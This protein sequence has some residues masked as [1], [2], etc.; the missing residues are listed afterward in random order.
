[1]A[2]PSLRRASAQFLLTDRL[3]LAGHA[4]LA[5]AATAVPSRFILLCSLAL[6]ALAPPPAAAEDPRLVVVHATRAV[7]GDSAEP[8]RRRWTAQ[9]DRNPADRGAA[10]GLATLARLTYDYA[11]AERL[12]RRLLADS[13]RPDRHSALARLGLARGLEGRGFS[14]EA[15]PHFVRAR[16]EARVSGDAPTEGE[17]LL[18]L[19]FIRARTEGLTV[20]EALLDTAALLI[21]DSALALRAQLRYRRAI[22][23]S[24][25]G[26]ADAPVEAE[27][28]IALARR[29]RDVRAEADGFR[30]LGQVLVYAQ[31]FDSALVV[32]RRAED[33]FRRARDRSALAA[34]LVWQ[35]QALG[36]LGRF[37]EMAELMRRARAEGEASRNPAT[38]AVAHRSLGALALMMGDYAAAARGL[39]TAL[40]ISTETGDSL[41][42]QTTRKFL[43]DVALAAGDLATAR[44]LTLEQLN[45]ARRTEQPA[46]A[47]EAHVLLA[48]LAMR[49]R[50]WDGAERHL[51]E[52]GDVLRQLPGAHDRL[53]LLHHEGRLAHAR[54]DLDQAERAFSAFVRGFTGQS[55]PELA[56]F[57]ARVR[58]ADIHAARG[59]LARAER[60]MRLSSEQLDEWR[61]GLGDA[62]LRVLAFQVSPS[63]HARAADPF[64]LDR[65]AAR[66][67]AAL[68]TGGR[69]DAAFA[70]AER[71]RAR[72]LKDRLFRAAGLRTDSAGALPAAGTLSGSAASVTAAE[73]AGQLPDDATALLEFIG[74]AGGAPATLF[75]IQRSG[76]RAVTVPGV[77]SL[78]ERVARFVA[79][80]EAGAG[81]DSLSRSLGASLLDP[82]LRELGPAVTRLIIVP[83]GPLH[84][85]PW[86]ALRLADGRL[87]VDRY[88]VSLAPSAAVVATL[89]HTAR[90]D[91]APDAARLLAFGDP[92]FPGARRAGDAPV[93]A[94][95]E[96]YMVA[97]DA[98]GGL[99]RLR[100]S[101]D[102]A[103][104]VA[105][106]AHRP[107]VRLRDD[108]SAA[109]L[110]TAALRDFRVIHFATHA[111]VDERS[112]S[113][114][115]LAL[116]PGGGES[117]FVGVG[118]LASLD[119]NADLVVLS[120][121]RSA[122]GRL[123]A[124]EGVQGLAT[125]LLQAGARAVVATNWQ[126][127]DREAV[128]LVDA[129]YRHLAAGLPVTEALR[130]AKREAIARGDSPREWAAFA[131]IGDPLV[132]VELGEPEPT[133]RQR[134]GLAV[135]ALATLGAV[136]VYWRSTRRR[137]I[138]E[139]R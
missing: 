91:P 112:V 16:E 18:T 48:E 26:R 56:L 114:T 105:R 68:A 24:L 100:A 75:V 129:F 127:G 137:R 80:L 55:D 84:Y 33:L 130:T 7:Q 115:A 25:R 136:A 118:D 73:I 81:A 74:G 103:R 122:R 47:Y 78:A 89:W 108:A 134:R 52:G 23:Y 31:R 125:S 82:G 13:L 20:G 99:P 67:L 63:Q 14:V 71:R 1:M 37:G 79:L 83:D 90:D 139:A 102:E 101:A 3:P 88:A 66:V 109:F 86:D 120:A 135:A 116:A 57:D 6:G 121:C 98:S 53:W 27:S 50:D 133:S 19:S 132:T 128:P 87:V 119:L 131:V 44:R 38:V 65:Q 40:A 42:V 10:L 95:A 45:H 124:G 64:E 21:P 30:V 110:K 8:L 4:P 123:V 77:D 107:E 36:N 85:V 70:L 29:A 104:R 49:E 34:H 22:M 35:A 46:E 9:L 32:L 51:R 54:G 138:S 59:D 76:L 94:A 43:A 62:E 58:L 96:T 15:R 5:H 69:S 97:F 11:G 106:Y 93:S 12:Y 126:V 117:G 28:S 72:E 61:K 113:R 41:G 39:E 17:V 60:E 111:L 2:A 92:V